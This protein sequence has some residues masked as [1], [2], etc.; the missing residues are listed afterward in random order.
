MSIPLKDNVFIVILRVFPLDMVLIVPH[1]LGKVIGHLSFRSQRGLSLAWLL[2]LRALLG[3]SLIFSWAVHLFG[4]G[5]L[6]L[7]FPNITLHYSTTTFLASLKTNF[8]T[9]KTTY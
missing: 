5:V 6:A 7:G 8:Y 9:L 1:L 2:R 4:E 3:K